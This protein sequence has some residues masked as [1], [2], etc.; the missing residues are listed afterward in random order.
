MIRHLRLLAFGLF[1]AL[2]LQITARPGIAQ[3]NVLPLRFTSDVVQLQ[4]VFG[5]APLSARITLLTNANGVNDIR[6]LPSDLVDA[7]GNRIPATGYQI[8][9]LSIASIP[10][11]SGELVTISISDLPATGTYTGTITVLY[12]GADPNNPLTLRVEVV[13]ATDPTATL[14]LEPNASQIVIKSTRGLLARRTS[15][16]TSTTF[17]LRQAADTPAQIVS[18]TSMRAAAADDSLPIPDRV[19]V[20]TPTA[21]LRLEPKVWQPIALQADLAQ[22]PAGHYSGILMISPEQGDEQQVAIDLFVR[23][24]WL[25]P[26]LVLLIG[27]SLSAVIS[28]MTATG[29]ARLSALRAIDHL[30]RQVA[31]GTRLPEESLNDWQRRL[32]GLNDRAQTEHPE[33]IQTEIAVIEAEIQVAL[34]TTTEHI[35]QLDEWREQLDYWSAQDDQ[36]LAAL[37][38]SPYIR[39][40]RAGI[41]QQRDLLTRGHYDYGAT[42]GILAQLSKDI[43]LTTTLINAFESIRTSTIPDMMNAQA[44]L[45]DTLRQAEGLRVGPLADFISLLKQ[46]KLIETGGEQATRSFAVADSAA[47]AEAVTEDVETEKPDIA[48]QPNWLQ[49]QWSH[50]HALIQRWLVPR[51]YLPVLSAL[52][53]ALFLILL[54][55]AGMEA[56]YANKATFGANFLGDYLGVLLWGIGADA[57]RKQLRNLESA[58]G[59]LRQR[60]GISDDS[61]T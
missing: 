52:L 1:I 27:V 56:L 7:A 48:D 33:A 36:Y 25:W 31:I 10:A 53:G 8:S 34:A 24:A 43:A 32:D 14:E 50:V 35:K 61:A 30:L 42:T 19:L 28:F 51:K 17:H 57:S 18:I 26:L 40:L 41:K 45:V 37:L 38:E 23:D 44:I 39:N 9:P 21:P 4:G 58:T 49:Q 2:L 47:A 16:T 12:T 15:L 22:L 54:L 3:D 46:H 13:V 29:T 59:Y 11:N 6:L 20:I 55:A 60:L 5:G